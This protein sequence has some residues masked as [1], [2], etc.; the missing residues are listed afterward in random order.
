MSYLGKTRWRDCQC[1]EEAFL[2]TCIISCS[3][4]PSFHFSFFHIFN[5]FNT[6]KYFLT[7]SCAFLLPLPQLTLKLLKLSDKIFYI[8]HLFD[9][10]S[11]FVLEVESQNSLRGNLNDF[12]KNLICYLNWRFN[13][14]LNS[15]SISLIQE[16]KI[17]IFIQKTVSREAPYPIYTAMLKQASC[18]TIVEH[19]LNISFDL[20][21]NQ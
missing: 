13:K 12:T 2:L 1:K 8:S 18:E 9:C 21:P 10:L 4:L 17:Q 15:L 20:F 7:P 6:L 14:R 16:D 11:D 5:Y 19:P 3:F